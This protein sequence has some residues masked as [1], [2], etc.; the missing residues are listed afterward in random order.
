MKDKI[1]PQSAAK[2][3]RLCYEH[4]AS[5]MGIIYSLCDFNWEHKS[6]LLHVLYHYYYY[7]F[8]FQI[9]YKLNNVKIFKFDS[10]LSSSAIV[11]I[12]YIFPHSQ[13][14]CNLI[15]AKLTNQLHLNVTSLSYM[16]PEGTY[17]ISVKFCA[18]KK[19][20]LNCLLINMLL[21]FLS[22]SGTRLLVFSYNFLLP[23]LY[24]IL[25]LYKCMCLLFLMLWVSISHLFLS[26]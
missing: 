15:F 25:F 20:K 22:L 13:R 19:T 2:K 4:D 21:F 26:V 1:V 14:A 23:F 17:L 5:L 24:F 18:K 8:F 9:I 12:K 10:A 11:G 6:I 3:C 7:Y 16:S